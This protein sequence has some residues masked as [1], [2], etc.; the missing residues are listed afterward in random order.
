MQDCYSSFWGFMVMVVAAQ[1][2][3][4][5]QYF[6]RC[7]QTYCLSY[8]VSVRLTCTERFIASS[9]FLSSYSPFPHLLPY[10][11]PSFT[12]LL[13]PSLSSSTPLPAPSLLHPPS[14]TLLLHSSPPFPTLY[15]HLFTLVLP[16]LPGAIWRLRWCEGASGVS[17]A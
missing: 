15:P 14:F 10:P 11:T 8:P 17:E 2:I 5:A 7:S 9:D 1:W 13:P 4:T 6:W 3:L 16:P 12:V